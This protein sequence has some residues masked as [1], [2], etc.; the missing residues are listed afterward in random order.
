MS[1]MVEISKGRF[2][3]TSHITTLEVKESIRDN[4][5]RSVGHVLLS[6]GI[7]IKLEKYEYDKLMIAIMADTTLEKEKV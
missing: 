3:N 5:H 6:N 1:Q 4:Y 2:I 7:T